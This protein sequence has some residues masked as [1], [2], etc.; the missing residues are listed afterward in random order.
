MLNTIDRYILRKF[1]GTFFFAILLIC[2]IAVIFDLAEQMDDMIEKKA[3]VQEI[4]LEYYLNFVPYF[5]NLFSHLFVFISVIFFTSKMAYNSEIVAILAGGIS[6]RR[7]MRPFFV[8]A[9][10]ISLFSFLL[11]AYVIPPANKVRW[12]FMEKY[13]KNP[14]NYFN[15]DIHRQILPGVF[16][17]M[18]SFNKT[19]GIAYRLSVE[20]FDGNQLVSKLNSDY[21]RWEPEQKAWRVF[22][23]TVR[24]FKGFQENLQTGAFL[25]TILPI[26]PSDFSERPEMIETM[27]FTQLNRRIA[28]QKLQGAENILESLIERNRRIAFPFATFILTLIGVSVAS[29]KVKGGI[30]LHIGFG[31]A[32][33]FSYLLFLQ[34]SS[35]FAI[36]GGLDPLLAVWIPNLIFLMIGLVLYWKAPK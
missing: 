36:N 11:G 1:L 35:Q 31:L 33:S 25:D 13:L 17:Y 29:R 5:A 4:L 18:E 14:Y 28:Q 6:F 27:T 16:V 12:A 21:A 34:V 10:I 3:P 22:N 19:S 23:Y 24:D 32:I 7:M 9:L 2:S 20:K 8:G 26:K 30:G 15:R